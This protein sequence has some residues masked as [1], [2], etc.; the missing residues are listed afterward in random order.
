MIYIR[1]SKLPIELRKVTS[2]FTH[3]GSLAETVMNTYSLPGG[4]MGPNGEL[5]IKMQLGHN[6]V[7]GTA[8]FRVRFAGNAIFDFT[9][10][11][12]V[13]SMTVKR[14]IFN[15]GLEN[16]QTTMA[17]SKNSYQTSGGPK[18]TYAIDTTVDQLITVTGVLSDIT[19]TMNLDYLRIILNK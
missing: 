4:M 1:G 5:D 16:A 8:R 19:N 14:F 3:T 7:A 18:V 9:M 15:T 2:I 13:P 6:E 17:N 11:A 12:N 10:A